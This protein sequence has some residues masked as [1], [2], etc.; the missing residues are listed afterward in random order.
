[1]KFEEGRRSGK[2]RELVLI[3]IFAF[4]LFGGFKLWG[5]NYATVN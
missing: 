4:V 5:E 3:I 2:S 1:M